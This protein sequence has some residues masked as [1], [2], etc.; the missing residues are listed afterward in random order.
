M[1]RTEDKSVKGFGGKAQKKDVTQKTEAKT[2][3]WDQN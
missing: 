1:H 2:G 3:G